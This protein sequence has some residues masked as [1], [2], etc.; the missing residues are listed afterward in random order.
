MTEKVL[1][2]DDDPNVLASYHRQL[3]KQ[4]DVEVAVGSEAGLRTMSVQGPF[5]VI[6]ADMN[7]P[8]MN[9]IQFLNA[10]KAHSPETVRMILTGNADLK[11]AMDAVNTGS[12]FRFLTKPC[13]PEVLIG[14]IQAGIEQYALVTAEKNLLKSTLTG[15]IKVMTEI[16]SMVNRTAFSRAERMRGFVSDLV[17]TMK[18]QDAW[19]YEV[20]AMLSQIGCM[21]LPHRL[22]EKVAKLEHLTAEED[23]LYRSHPAVAS[24]LLNRIPRLGM[25]SQ[26]IEG[27]LRSFRS[28]DKVER[29]SGNEHIALGSQILRA[30]LD[31]DSLIMLGRSN[32]E[33]IRVFE[34]RTGEY[35]PAIVAALKK[36]LVSGASQK[37]EQII[38]IGVSEVRIGMIADQ[39]IMG[40]D[41]MLLVPKKHQITYPVLLLL[42]NVAK[43]SGVCEPFRVRVPQGCTEQQGETEPALQIAV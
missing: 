4:F 24:K 41:G 36:L 21:M 19:Q 31:Y 9:G 38:D 40:M 20:A 8:R 6:L 10:V 29:E 13:E 37:A 25:I 28:F 11:T 35:N 27:Q 34:Q 22:L 1:C 14:A 33:V 39:D 18:L 30:A 32:S 15:S 23:E 17:K 26:M 3:R 2:V 43:E 12:I 5:A 42:R 16:L 7:M